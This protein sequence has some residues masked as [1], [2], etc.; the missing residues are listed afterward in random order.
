MK[1]GPGCP[2]FLLTFGFTLRKPTYTVLLSISET[3]ISDLC[4]KSNV[5]IKSSMIVRT[6]NAVFKLSFETILL[7]DCSGAFLSTFRH[8]LR[9]VR[10]M[11]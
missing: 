10:R 6:F 7:F 1:P 11:L 9:K 4:R 8:C 2:D 3:A 5:F